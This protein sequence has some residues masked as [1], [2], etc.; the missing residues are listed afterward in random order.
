MDMAKL[1]ALTSEIVKLIGIPRRSDSP[2]GGDLFV[3]PAD[4]AQQEAL[5]KIFK[6]GNRTVTA[7]LPNS[8]TG[9]KGIVHR[10]PVSESE[11]DLLDLLGPQ[12]VIKV[13]RFTKTMGDV[14]MPSETIAL[15]FKDFLPTRVTLVALSFK[16][17]TYYPSPFKCS[18]C[19]R[20]GHTKNHC[21]SKL[22]TA[23]YAGRITTHQN[24]VPKNA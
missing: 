24:L 11:A 16:V 17:H 9:R 13:E 5:L 7:A 22:T 10:V 1:K 8:M 2:R 19:Y 23:G 3:Y 18:K 15:T 6:I 20:L 4:K 21:N 12:G 14:R